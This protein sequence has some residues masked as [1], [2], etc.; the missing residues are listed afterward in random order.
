MNPFKW[1]G[2]SLPRH[3]V[4]WEV[5]F[6]LP[7]YVV[8]LFRIHSQDGLTVGWAAWMAF[9]WAVGGIVVAV[10]FWYMAVLPMKRKKR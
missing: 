4:Y 1:A 8:F 10:I 9:V 7:L 5:L 3:I 2:V 6:S